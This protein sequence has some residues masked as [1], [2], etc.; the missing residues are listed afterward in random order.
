MKLITL[1]LSSIFC[2]QAYAV[3]Y[4]EQ[5]GLRVQAPGSP[6]I[7][8]VEGGERRWIPNPETVTNLF[9]DYGLVTVDIGSLSIPLGA[10][11]SDRAILSHCNTAGHPDSGAVFLIDSGTKRHIVSPEI[12]TKYNFNWNAVVNVPCILLQYIPNGPALTN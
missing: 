4:N 2:M 5:N 6:A 10:N 9:A 12:M 3:D 1:V 8:L 11:I 7:Y